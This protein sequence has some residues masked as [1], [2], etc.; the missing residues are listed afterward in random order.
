MWPIGGPAMALPMALCG[1]LAVIACHFESSLLKR[2]G[3]AFCFLLSAVMYIAKSFNLDP[4]KFASSIQ[5]VL[6]IDP[7][8]S[9]EYVVAAVV[10]VIALALA[11]IYAPSAPK[12]ASRDQ[13]IMAAMTVAL[14]INFDTVAT[15]GAR[16]TYKMSAPEGTPIDSAIVQNHIAPERVRAR[17]LIVIL[18]EAWGVPNND[19]D[20]AIFNRIWGANRWDA[21]Y[22]VSTG[23]NA[24]FGSTTNAE[25]REWCSVWSDYDRYD[26]AN[27]NCLPEKFAKAG[28]HTTAVHTFEGDFFERSKWYPQIGFQ[29]QMF[30]ADLIKLKAKPCGGVFPGACDRDVPRIIGDELRKTPKN[31][32][33]LVYWLT[34]NTHL[35]VPDD[36][37][38][39]TENCQMAGAEW[40]KNLPMLCR[41]YLL[42]KRLADAIT[43]EIM[44]PDFP[45]A[46]ILLVGDHMPP[47]F[48][49]AL[50]SRFET[51]HVPWIMLRSR[52]ALER[53]RSATPAT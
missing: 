31:Q 44:K 50:R 27:S 29:Q 37:S 8:K 6:E 17:N 34:L 15:A 3:V 42:Q 10:V 43:A 14:L 45:E 5:F 46:D 23:T 30:R 19:H 18:V 24:Y 53:D 13:R 47:F 41:S 26:F 2:L 21:R 48:P 49:R 40:N 20:R 7:L 38:L 32:R 35:P 28:F 39:E 25:L 9:P 4:L 36:K 51:E 12:L 22:A 33:N 16:G 1:L 52:A 11:V